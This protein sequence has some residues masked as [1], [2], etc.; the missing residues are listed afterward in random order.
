M[1][2]LPTLVYQHAV[3][4]RAKP[5]PNR[6]PFVGVLTRV[7]LPSDKSPAGSR[8]HRVV[9]A[10]AAVEE[11]LSTLIGMGVAFKKEWDGHDMR[12]KCGVITEAEIVGDEVRVY[13]HLYDH[14]FPEVALA[15]RS[16]DMGMSYEMI[17]CTVQD[18]R[19][20]PWVITTLTFC[21]AAILLR[22]KAAYESSSI[23]IF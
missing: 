19:A 9:L 15:I 13:G 16:M 10:Q 2:R 14:D 6:L 5:H 11:A 12:Q 4:A 20:E 18:L 22:K 3:H 8:G 23:K 21:G 7:G 17:S 1:P